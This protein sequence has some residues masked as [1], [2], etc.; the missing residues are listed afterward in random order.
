VYIDQQV[1]T[2]TVDLDFDKNK[3]EKVMNMIRGHDKI[4]HRDVI[5]LLCFYSHHLNLVN[6]R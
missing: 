1:S 4:R 3:L 2:V 6:P 5:T